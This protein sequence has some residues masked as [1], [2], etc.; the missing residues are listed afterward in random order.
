MTQPLDD[1]LIGRTYSKPGTSAHAFAVCDVL[2]PDRL[3]IEWIGGRRQTVYIGE[4]ERL[5]REYV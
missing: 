3:I 4:F 1:S 2:S 5:T